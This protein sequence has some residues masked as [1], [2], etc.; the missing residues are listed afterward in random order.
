MYKTFLMGLWRDRAAEAP[1]GSPK[2]D[3]GAPY[4]HGTEAPEKPVTKA[5]PSDTEKRLTALE[6]QLETTKADLAEARNSERYWADRARGARVEEDPIPDDE[7]EPNP[8]RPAITVD[9]KPEKLL[10]DLSV[11]GLKALRD[12][13]II[14]AE[15]FDAKLDKLETSLLKRVD[16][17]LETAQR[18]NVIDTELAKFPDLIEDSKRVAQGLPA[19]TELYKRA[20]NN[21]REMIADDAALKNSPG[22]LLTAVRMAK[23]ELD[24]EAKA[25]DTQ[26]RDTGEAR[27]RRIESQMGERSGAGTSEEDGGEPDSLSPTARSIVNNLS[28]FGATEETFRAHAT[29]GSPAGRKR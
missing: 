6:K 10:D 8:S 7:P 5:E 11:S 23:K 12:R 20:S 1:N 22:A 2:I 24:L 9:D 21:L 15:E 17:K 16:Q 3:P 13:G 4:E 25:A 18:H 26:G 27:R 14:T 29:N 19:K 28:R